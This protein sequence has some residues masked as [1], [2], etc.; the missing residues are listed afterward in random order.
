MEGGLE[1]ILDVRGCASDRLAGSAGEAR[2]R[3]LFDDLIA[4]LDL[5]PVAPA[6]WHVFPKPAGVTGLVALAESH[7]ACHSFPEAGYLSLNVYSC[8]SRPEPN[9]QSLLTGRLGPC[10]IEVRRIE[11][12]SRAPSPEPLPHA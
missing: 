5:H 6:T 4:A 10:R 9:W 2:L 7:L 11:R 1:W 8:R 12:G 3:G